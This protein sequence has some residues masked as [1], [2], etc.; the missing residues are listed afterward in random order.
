MLRMR[1]FSFYLSQSVADRR[2]VTSLVAAFAVMAVTIA[3]VGVYGVFAYSVTSRT[4][5]IGV[6]LALGAGR[7][8]VIR[9]VLR[10][11][12]GL[13]VTGALAG[14]VMLFAARRLIENQLFEITATDAKTLTA[15]ALTILTTALMA[16]YVPA[17]RASRVDPT[18]ALRVE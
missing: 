13:G 9:S 12:L 3:L 15:I 14:T 1:E 18:T 17:R 6:R 4:R 16:C 8:R 11:A 10:E 7:G 2:L 5:D